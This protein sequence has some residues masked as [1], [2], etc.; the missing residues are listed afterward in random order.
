M[1]DPV[2]IVSLGLQ[3]CAIVKTYLGAVKSRADDLASATQLADRFQTSL[4][5]LQTISIQPQHQSANSNVVSCVTLCQ[6][7]INALKQ[8]VSRL[9]SAG[10]QITVKE[11][12]K[13]K[14]KKYSYPFNRADVQKLETKLTKAN[15]ALQ[16][17]LSIFG[18]YVH[19]KNY[20]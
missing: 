15:N 12:L 16:T 11:Q 3:T 5:A 10:S 13:E 9:C 7:E 20:H 18:V 17:A 8:V 6:N 2:G 19:D 1:V 14:A 4:N